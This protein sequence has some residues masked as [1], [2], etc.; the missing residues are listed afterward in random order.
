MES[1]YTDH[2]TKEIIEWF[3]YTKTM[4]YDFVKVYGASDG[5]DDFRLE[6][7][8]HKK[9]SGTTRTP[10][11]IVKVVKENPSKSMKKIAKEMCT[12]RRKMRGIV[13]EGLN[14]KFYMFERRYLLTVP[15]VAQHDDSQTA[16]PSPQLFCVVHHRE[17]DEQKAK[18]ALKAAISDTMTNM[19]RDVVAKACPSFQSHLE[20]VLATDGDHIK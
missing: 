19:N 3:K 14:Y 1:L 12:R 5:K 15:L 20:K 7:K 18:E 11:F 2:K 16:P 4:V 8:I 9:R 13:K 10:K 6:C 17:G